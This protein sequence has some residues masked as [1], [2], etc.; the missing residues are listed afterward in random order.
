VRFRDSGTP[1][2][3]RCPSIRTVVVSEI[4]IPIEEK[5]VRVEKLAIPAEYSHQ[6]LH[7][8]SIE[9]ETNVRPNHRYRLSVILA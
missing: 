3:F 2:R 6:Q 1:L 8:P 7:R 4:G 5:Q 9:Q